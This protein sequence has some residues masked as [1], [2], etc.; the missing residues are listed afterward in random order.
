MHRASLHLT[1]LDFYCKIIGMAGR[2]PKS[3][4][5]R[6]TDQL[7]VPLTPEQKES[8]REAAERSGSEMTA[9]ARSVLLKAAERIN[10][11]SR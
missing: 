1:I 3:P 6:K 9:W 7:R 11:K 8:L 10:S 2:P 4:E 5:D